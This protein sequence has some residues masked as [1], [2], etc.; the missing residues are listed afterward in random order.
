MKKHRL[1]PEGRRKVEKPS[2]ERVAGHLG[3]S[4]LGGS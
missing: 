1:E 3:V 4:D 2:S